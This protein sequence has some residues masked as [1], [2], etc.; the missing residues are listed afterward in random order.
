[1]L[2]RA[3]V[4]KMTRALQCRLALAN[5]KIKHG[6]ENMSLDSIEPKLEYEIK[7]KRP[8]SS[9]DAMSDISSAIS[10][11]LYA[12]GVE[13]SPLAAPLFSDAAR[14]S[15]G[16]Q[17]RVKYSTVMKQ[18]ASSSHARRKVRS[19]AAG[20]STWKKAYKLPESSPVYHKHSRYP[21]T[22][23]THSLSFVSETSTAPDDAASPLL[24]EDDDAD[25]PLH[26]FQ[27][28]SSQIRSS[29]PRTP[30]PSFTRPSRR[31][32]K[33]LRAS[34]IGEEGADLLLFLATSPS[35]A[36]TNGKGGLRRSSRII[37]PPST[38]PAKA[39]PLPSSHMDT[40]GGTATLFPGFG[41]NTPGTAG[42]NFA[43]Y[44]NVTPSP[45]QV[46]FKTPGGAKTPLAARE[47]RRRLNFD[48]L[49]PPSNTS[50]RLDRRR[51]G[52]ETGL[53]MDLGGELCS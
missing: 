53:G 23:H 19:T 18:P 17:K 50:P 44:L 3:Q 31:Q 27:V 4:S 43:D 11:R 28:T 34:N 21:L 37:N 6:W 36:N 24:S 16:S 7:R 13:S 32:T 8:T 38:P 15:G 35:P 30:S 49:L 47:A 10:E 46:P 42:F 39:T 40:P 45:G 12:A 9:N 22:S 29:P 25:L 5:V 51:S 41:A 33:S 52:K 14:W 2:R 26:S 20:S 48:S 1:V